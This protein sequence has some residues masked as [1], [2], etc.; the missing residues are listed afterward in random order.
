MKN[1]LITADITIRKAMKALDKTAEKC[2]LVID[3]S[4]KLIGTI[5]DGDIR[6]AILSDKGFR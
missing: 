4:G 3:E 5:T 2:L 1:I 6:R